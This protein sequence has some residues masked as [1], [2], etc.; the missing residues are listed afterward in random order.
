M[1]GS[2]RKHHIKVGNRF[3]RW[4][5]IGKAEPKVYGDNDVRL[6]WLCKCD[7]GT[8]RDVAEQGLI[9]GKSTSCGCKRKENPRFGMMKHGKAHTKLYRVYNSMRQRCLNPNNPNYK[10]YGER[11][12]RICSDWLGEDGFA[13]F[14]E[15]AVEKGYSDT[16]KTTLD[17]IDVNGN[18]EPSNCRWADYVTQA[19]N[20]RNNRLITYQGETHTVSEWARITGLKVG[21]INSRL[22]RKKEIEQVLS[23][24][25]WAWQK[26]RHKECM[27]RKEECQTKK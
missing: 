1:G 6:R 5:V 15:W 22:R 27:R 23:P 9:N 2:T 3:G 20:M 14:Y 13:N 7:C 11:G 4:T 16:V 17:R 26:E 19:N 18:Y 25:K 12:I 24:E 10:N 8:I 21:T